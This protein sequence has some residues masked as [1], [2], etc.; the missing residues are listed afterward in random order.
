MSPKGLTT[1][2]RTSTLFPFTASV[3][4]GLGIPECPRSSQRKDIKVYVGLPPQAL[5]V[6]PTDRDRV[7]QI[8]FRSSAQLS[9][10]ERRP[11]SR[12]W[13]Q[14]ELMT[15]PGLDSSLRELAERDRYVFLGLDSDP[16]QEILSGHVK[17]LL[18]FWPHPSREG[19]VP[20]ERQCDV[21]TP[22]RV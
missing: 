22:A 14:P 9:P 16:E 20:I 7:A 10:K 5:L 19:S 6:A 21:T 4:T 11:R 15:R 17:S 12:L 13:N 3:Q 1:G 8:R 18:D 2:P